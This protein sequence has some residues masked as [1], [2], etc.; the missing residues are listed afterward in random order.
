[1]YAGRGE[2]ESGG[3]V[4]VKEMVRKVVREMV[5]VWGVVRCTVRTCTSNTFLFN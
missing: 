3:E 4:R 2:G 5:R 1:M